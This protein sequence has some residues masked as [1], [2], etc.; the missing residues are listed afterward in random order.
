MHKKILVQPGTFTALRERSTDFVEPGLKKPEGKKRMKKNRDA[1]A[2]Q[3]DAF[4]AED[5]YSMLL[6]FQALDAAGKD[7]TVK[8]VLRKVRPQ[9]IRFTDFMPPSGEEQQHDYLW[10]IHKYAPAR[11]MI[12]VFH[13]SYYE[14]VTASRVHPEFIL[15]QRIPGINEISDIKDL[16]W[17]E[18][19]R[20]INDFEKLLT[21]NGTIIL[22]F[23]LHVSL[24]KQSKRFLKRLRRKDKHWKFSEKD[25]EEQQFR[26]KYLD[27]YEKAINHT[28]TANAPWYVIPADRKWYMRMLVSEIILERMKSLDLTYPGLSISSGKDMEAVRELLKKKIQGDN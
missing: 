11:K 7:S 21:E 15:D 3:Q 26:E 6:V 14:D 28:S 9:G 12:N 22:K 1:I 2:E 19:Y 5:R 8:H 20:Q 27:V 17:T 23:F 24:E 13:R 4:Y 25:I 10:R 16:F 18:R